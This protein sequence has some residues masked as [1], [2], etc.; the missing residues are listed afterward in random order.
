MATEL[1]K[2]DFAV[3]YRWSSGFRS[4][5][6]SFNARCQKRH[7]DGRWYCLHGFSA[8]YRETVGG[9]F[10]TVEA[11]ITF[12]SEIGIGEPIIVDTIMLGTDSK[13]LHYWHEL[14][15]EGSEDRRATQEGLMLHVD[16]DPVKVSAMSGQLMTA[17]SN[18]AAGHAELRRSVA[19][20][21]PIRAVGGTT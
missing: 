13:R 4:W 15:V 9:T 6:C 3:D 17:A 18:L 10:Y 12:E 21:R 20:G 7:T 19:F 8:D 5:F 14:R 11:H 1:A 16:I 2:P